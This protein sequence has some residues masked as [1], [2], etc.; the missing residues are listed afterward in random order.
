MFNKKIAPMDFAIVVGWKAVIK[1]IFPDCVDGDLLKLVHLSNEFRMLES[2]RH[3]QEGDELECK[4]EINSIINDDTGKTVE[5]KGKIRC[6]GR[7]ILEVTSKFFFRGNFTN[8]YKYTFRRKE[9]M[10]FFFFFF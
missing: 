6:E 3:L 9:V 5:V 10:L 2:N 1:S 8:D 7:G 4:A